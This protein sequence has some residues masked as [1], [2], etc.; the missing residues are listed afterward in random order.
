MTSIYAL[1]LSRALYSLYAIHYTQVWLLQAAHVVSYNV[2]AN[3]FSLAR[4]SRAFGRASCAFGLAPAPTDALRRRRR[5]RRLLPASNNQ[6]SL[7]GALSRAFQRAR[8]LPPL[9]YS[10]PRYR[11]SEL[12]FEVENTSRNCA[13]TPAFVLKL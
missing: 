9:L 8:A 11:F 13:K 3:T 6:P 4:A 12:T 2:L 1:Y 7:D 5:P 10:T